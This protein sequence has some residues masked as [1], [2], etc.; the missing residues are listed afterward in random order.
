MN[1]YEY[2]HSDAS[3]LPGQPVIKATRLSVQ[4]LPGPMAEGWTGQQVLENY[5][6]LCPETPQVIVTFDPDDADEP[7]PDR[8]GVVGQTRPTRI[9]RI[10]RS[11]LRPDWS[12]CFAFADHRRPVAATAVG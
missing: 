2:I 12:H 8:H 4:C 5:P 7:L 3:A 11:R 1:P 10:I 9:C 6:Q